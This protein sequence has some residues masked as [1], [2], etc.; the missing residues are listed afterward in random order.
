L[1]NHICSTYI[2]PRTNNTSD[3]YIQNKLR[4]FTFYCLKN[5][6]VE[7]KLYQY[8]LSTIDIWFLLPDINTHRRHRRHRR[9][10]LRDGRASRGRGSRGRGSRERG[11]RGRGSRGR[12]SRRRSRPFPIP[13]QGSRSSSR[14]RRP[15]HPTI[16]RR[17]GMLL[18][19][20]LMRTVLMLLQ[21]LQH[22]QLSFVY[23]IS[24]IS[25]IIFFYKP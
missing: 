6:K 12:G 20:E 11:S 7:W 15:T 25:W 5:K 24:C 14:S 13:N 9:I 18:L 2:T 16:E 22:L 17:L 21:Q 19:M 1:R 23:L 3:K 8:P 10:H 4:R